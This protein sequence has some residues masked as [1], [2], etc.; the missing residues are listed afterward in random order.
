MKPACSA[1][2]DSRSSDTRTPGRASDL[3]KE[4]SSASSRFPDKQSAGF[5]SR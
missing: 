3:V 2:V 5:S 1:S 4:Q